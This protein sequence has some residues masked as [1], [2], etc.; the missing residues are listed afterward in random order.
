MA[1]YAVYGLAENSADSHKLEFIARTEF[2]ESVWADGGFEAVVAFPVE[3]MLQIDD[4]GAH[5]GPRE[6][7]PG[8]RGSLIAEAPRA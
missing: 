5:V 1:E 3:S 2:P 7:Q 4:E 6:R 8:I